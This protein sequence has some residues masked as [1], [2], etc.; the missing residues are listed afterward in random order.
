MSWNYINKSC[1]EPKIIECFIREV[2]AIL[3]L[4]ICDVSAIILSKSLCLLPQI[5]AALYQGPEG[6]LLTLLVWEVVTE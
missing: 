2:S 3:L 5:S 1:V 6:K 4:T